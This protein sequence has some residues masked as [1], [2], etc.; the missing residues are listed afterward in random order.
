ME[1]A[2]QLPAHADQQARLARDRVRVGLRTLRPLLLL[3]AL[4][5]TACVTFMLRAAFLNRSF[6]VFFDESIYLTISQN[7]AHSSS[8]TYDGKIPFFLHP[9][10]FFLIEAGF[11]DL[12]RPL[13]NQI[14]QIF[15][16]RYVNVFFAALTSGLILLLCRRLANWAAGLAAAA[17]FAV[18]PFLI[19]INSR[20]LLETVATFWVLLGLY[21]L[22]KP[23]DEGRAAP[24]TLSGGLAFGAALLTNEPSAFLTLLPLAVCT[25]TGRPLPR[26]RALSAALAAA[27][28]YSLYPLGVLLSGTWSEFADQKL[29]GLRRFAGLLQESGF[30]AGHGPSFHSAVLSHAD[31]FL[32]TYALIGYGAVVIVLLA[33]FGRGPGRLVALWGGC[34]YLLQVYSVF[35]GTNEEQYFYYVVVLAIV[36]SAVGTAQLWRTGTEDTPTRIRLV[37]AVILGLLPLFFVWSGHVWTERHLTPDNGYERLFAYIEHS[38]PP[39]SRISATDSTQIALLRDHP[40]QVASAGT[41]AAVTALRVQYLMVSTQLVH[42]GYSSATPELLAW[43]PR[44]AVLLH[45]FY[46]PTDGEL[47]FYQIA[48]VPSGSQLP[49]LPPPQ[50][51]LRGLGQG[52]EAPIGPSPQ[53]TPGQG[54]TPPP[55]AAVAGGRDVAGALAG[56]A[57]A[58]GT[59]PPAVQPQNGTSLGS[60]A[61]GQ[62]PPPAPLPVPTQSQTPVPTPVPALAP[63]PTP[64][65]T[66]VPT[67]VPAP[68]PTPT[69][70]PPTPPPGPSPPRGRPTQAPTPA[71]AKSPRPSGSGSQSR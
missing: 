68:P 32:T 13:G 25:V 15:A 24:S 18:E 22:T 3:T 46:G 41:P 11:L 16:V 56:S 7:T 59:N 1:R 40:Y 36:A 70:A 19:R 33:L 21:L 23:R 54:L 55:P 35:F 47:L 20:N 4:V 64:V 65:P 44:H 43:L 48:G 34:A 17:A 14:Q 5:I 10:L 29:R 50:V 69:A 58:P 52:Q 12:T 6:E 53:S 2:G 57:P 28:L 30:N 62:P 27:A 49:A 42:D 9:P 51:D 61:Q 38:V 67:P 63:T 39:G 26:T 45:R 71:P 31:Q 37:R 66:S 8:I 60:G